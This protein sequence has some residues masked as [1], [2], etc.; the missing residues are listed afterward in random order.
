M[1]TKEIQYKGQTRPAKAGVDK[2]ST[3]LVLTPEYFEDIYKN[4]F[5]NEC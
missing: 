2:G 1:Q 3:T 5:L 4:I